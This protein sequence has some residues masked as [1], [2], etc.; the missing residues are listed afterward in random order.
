MEPRRR[1]E[2]EVRGN[3]GLFVNHLGLLYLIWFICCAL[4]LFINPFDEPAKAKNL[5]PSRQSQ[6]KQGEDGARGEKSFCSRQDLEIL[7]TRLLE[8]LPRY[9]NR[10]S[11]RAR[12][13]SRETDVYVYV[14][15]AG[16]PEFK[17][18]PLNPSGYTTNVTNSASEGVEQVFFTTLERQY[19]AGKAVELQQFHW[20][21]LTKTDSGWRFVMMFSRTGFYPKDEPPIPP[22]DSSDGVI[23]QGIETWLRDCRAGSV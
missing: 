18:L 14:L 1:E 7:T 3:K 20:L 21:F 23:A 4:W 6:G 9:A 22:R 8:D 12:R 2:R 10:V 17:P 19:T 11:Q 13:S 15:V 5:T 16:K